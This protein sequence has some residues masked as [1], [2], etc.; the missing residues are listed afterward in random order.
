M[1]SRLAVRATVVSS[2]LLSLL[3]GGVSAVF[4]QQKTAAAAKPGELTVERIFAEPSLS[5]HL[6]HGIAWS[7]DSKRLSYFE[8]KGSDK[9][10][11]EELWAMGAATGERSLLI[12]AEK[13]ESI[14]P[15]PSSKQAQET[16]AGQHAP[17]QHQW[18]PGGD[19]L[20]LE[21]P[22]A[23]TWFDLKTHAA[24]VLVN[25]KED[26]GDAEISPDGKYVSFVRNY[27]LWLV[28]VTDGK[29]RALTTG[30]SE[31][32]RKGEL[33]WV[34][35]EELD[36]FTAYWW[37]PDSSAI[38]YLEMDERKVPQFPLV[39]FE[40]FTG[41]AELQRYPVPGGANPVVRVLVVP[42]AGGQA[43]PMDLGMETDMYIPRVN[44]L[45][46][47]K[48]LA[49]QRLNRA[50]TI[51]EVLLSDTTTGK[52]ATLLSDKDAYWINVTDDLR[53]LKDGKRFL[54]SSERS[55]YRHLYLYDFS[56]KQP[57]QLTKGDWEVSHVD[58][59]DEANDLVYLTATEKSPLERH[60]YRVGLDGSGFTRITTE[61]GTHRVNFAPDAAIYVDTF[62]NASTPPRQDLYR[63]DGRKLAALNENKV[64]ELDEYH[65]SP[66]EFFTIK[67]HDGMLLNCSMIKPPN[68]DPAKKYPVLV[69]TYGGPQVQVVVNA[70][71]GSRFLWHQLMA[72]KGY[73][74][75]SLDNRGSAGRGHLFEEPIHYRFG[76]Q[77]LSD[78]RDGTQ[79]LKGQPYV[80]ANRIGIWGWGY[81][82]QMTL[83]AMF[84]APQTFKVG[85]AGGPVTDW[86]FYD[87]IY[88]ERYIG[89]LPM[90]ADSYKES[91][92]IEN[93]AKL[94][95]KLLIAHG[96]G[97]DNVH[98]SN[99]LALI[100]DL[101]DAGKYVE[102]MAFPGRGHAVSDPPA[103]RLLW[104][105]V[106]KFFLDNL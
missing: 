43:R 49:I 8:T 105:R 53:F 92:P 19:A 39:D 91:A 2:L 79:W 51:L 62:S 20:L 9:A 106:T 96:T 22:H 64:M 98:Y 66:I 28:S 50:Q 40:S 3:S 101:I 41:E 52:S 100:D 83:H 15:A 58:A 87:T 67:S 97:D 82:G 18:A 59:V 57:L 69:Y 5:G 11:K 65:L 99:T 31:E 103:Q 74:I 10:A 54:W 104:D 77:E 34:Y 84:E 68:F 78:Q 33:D 75:F 32:V 48:H 36:I 26:L 1:R 25:G 86:R 6:A 29:E 44:W 60:L 42:A 30:G 7:P 4:A 17:L 94:K 89:L 55:G 12:S 81:G 90:Y 71:M 72:Q 88:T 61:D 46:D 23:L 24:R 45:P 13:L 47:S 73:I 14:P 95:G 93:A 85:F 102:V 38:A 70:W 27:N 21:G 63:A 35:P 80:D 37:A 76:A 56:G 16:G